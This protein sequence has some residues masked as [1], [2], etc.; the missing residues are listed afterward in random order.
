MLLLDFTSSVVCSTI[1]NKMYILA[2]IPL[3]VAPLALAA[4]NVIQIASAQLLGNQ[5]SSNDPGTYRDAGFESQI[6]N[7]YFQFYGPYSL[8]PHRPRSY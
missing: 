7:T 8:K 1:A 3:F 6:G 2:A 4:D 5:T